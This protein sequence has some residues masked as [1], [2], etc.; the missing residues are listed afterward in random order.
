M[1]AHFGNLEVRKPPLKKVNHEQ[2][3]RTSSIGHES[4][5]TQD[6]N[7]LRLNSTM[8]VHATNKSVQQRKSSVMSFHSIKD[9]AQSRSKAKDNVAVEYGN[10][11]VHSG[12]V[13]VYDQR[14]VGSEREVADTMR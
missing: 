7:H 6:D 9:S 1:N 5:A 2:K 3:P 12:I 10:A 8:D 14:G 11:E 4:E 13:N